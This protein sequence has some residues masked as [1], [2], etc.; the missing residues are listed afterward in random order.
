MALAIEEEQGVFD[1]LAVLWIAKQA[2]AD[3]LV[4]P[5][6]VR[7]DEAGLMLGSRWG[8]PWLGVVG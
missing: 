4:E 3:P 5:L 7:V 2:A 6:L 8:I 1:D